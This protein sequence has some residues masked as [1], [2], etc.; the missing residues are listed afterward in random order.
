[1][2]IHNVIGSEECSNLF[3]LNIDIIDKIS[4]PSDLFGKEI[5]PGYTVES[6]YGTLKFKPI[7]V[8]DFSNNH[9]EFE[10]FKLCFNDIKKFLIEKDLLEKSDCAFFMKKT[11]SFLPLDYGESK[12]YDFVRALDTSFCC[13]LFET[14][15]SLSSITCTLFA[16]CDYP[17]WRYIQDTLLYND[18]IVTQ[19]LS[20]GTGIY[21][22][23]FGV[24]KGKISDS[25]AHTP[26]IVYE[27]F[28]HI[29]TRNYLSWAF[30]CASTNN[31]LMN[32]CSKKIVQLFT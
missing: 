15:V 10:S 6:D 25:R 13:R 31:S 30:Y 24:C 27:V 28:R 20:F 29:P 16:P 19:N 22:Q 1:M 9:E 8:P 21:L 14:G 18:M 32:S 26:E 5:L 12:I 11:I 4:S 17:G 7:I 3:G 2:E 23:S